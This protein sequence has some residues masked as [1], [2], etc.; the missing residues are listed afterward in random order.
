MNKP[1]IVV[2]GVTG[3][4]KTTMARRLASLYRVP[5]VELDALF[6]EPNW[7]SAPLE[8]FRL[9]ISEATACDSWVVDGNY[10]AAHDITWTI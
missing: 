2:L 3:S 6:W 10:S 1:R 4:G 5:H 8:R 9:R 7:V